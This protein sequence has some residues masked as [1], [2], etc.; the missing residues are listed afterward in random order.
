MGLFQSHHPEIRYISVNG[1]L[2]SL[3]NNV[4]NCIFFHS[5]HISLIALSYLGFGMICHGFGLAN[6]RLRILQT[7]SVHITLHMGHPLFC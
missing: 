6:F 1:G 7:S 4:A 2:L 5:I 3:F